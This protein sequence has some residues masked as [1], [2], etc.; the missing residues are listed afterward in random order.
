MSG[1]DTFPGALRDLMTDR[2]IGVLALARLVP[3]DRAYISR[4]ARGRQPPSAQIARRLD[5]ILDAGGDLAELAHPTAGRAAPDDVRAT[6]RSL[7]S[8]ERRLGG[9]RSSRPLSRRSAPPPPPLGITMTGSPPQR[10]P[11][12]SPRGSHTTRNSP[13]RPASSRPRR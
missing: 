4:L 7:I 12:R 5:D 3:C 8:M 2:G 11:V 9:T 13:P 1:M 10:K 6:S